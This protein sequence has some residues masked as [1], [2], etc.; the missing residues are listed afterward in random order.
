M[1]RITEL[2]RQFGLSRST[3][4]YYDRIGL[5]SPSG[6]SGANYRCYSDADRERLA[7]ICSLRQAGVDIEGIRA[8]LASSGDDP[9]AVLQRR[10]NEIGGEIQALQ[11][12]QRLLAGM[13][14]LKGEGGPKSALD[15]EMFVSMLRAAGMDDNAMKQL[16]VEFERREPQAHH[17][18][19][20]SLGISENEALQIRKWSAD[21]GKV[22]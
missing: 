18:F 4:L 13:L 17:A 10:L 7:S 20:L 12:K 16:H 2:A 19:L 21:M 1:F 22:A 6:R 9:G 8:I 11:T 14:R 3:L 15:K 5:L